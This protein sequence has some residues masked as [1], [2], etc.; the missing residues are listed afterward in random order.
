M[1]VCVCN[2]ISDREIRQAV[3]LGVRSMVQ[4]RNELGVGTCC[5]K[6]Q[7]CAKQV[8]R[9]SLQAQENATPGSRILINA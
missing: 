8:L 4:L 7:G 1:I 6:C 5:G 9:E 3:Q 2:N